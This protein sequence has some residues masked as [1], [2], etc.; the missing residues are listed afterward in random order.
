AVND[1]PTLTSVTTLTGATED[2]AFSI[3][4]ATLA[5]AANEADVDS[6]TI[7]F[8]IEGVTT[9]T[10]TKNGSAVVAGTT[11]VASGDTLSWTPA[12]NANGTLNA[13]TV[14][15]HDGSL[16]ST[17]AVQVQVTVGAVNDAPTLTSIT[18]LTGATE[19]TPYSITYAAL[20]AAANE[21][22]VD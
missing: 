17:P 15:A 5:G 2:T 20:A 3:T 12:T 8:R 7:N 16:A 11:I 4:Y 22:D 14:V 10:L 13:F 19:D 6:A 21:A 9:G 18:T 1:A